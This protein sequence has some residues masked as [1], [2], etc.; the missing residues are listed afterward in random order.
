MNSSKADVSTW[1]W[2]IS[3]IIV[4]ALVF[5]AAYYNLGQITMQS[6]KQNVVDKYNALLRNINGICLTSVGNTE[7]IQM[8]LSKEVRAIYT[9]ATPTIP[10]DKADL[11]VTNGNSTKGIYLC[12]QFYTEMDRDE[13]TCMRTDCEID[14]L[15][16]GKPTID[17]MMEK[18]A[19]LTGGVYEFNLKVI[20][21]DTNLV[22]ICNADGARCIPPQACNYIT[23]ASCGREPVLALLNSKNM[24]LLADTSP[25][26]VCCAEDDTAIL[27]KNIANYFGG[28]KVLIVWEDKNIDPT[29]E[30]FAP[31]KEALPDK[32]I[33]SLRHLQRIDY[34]SIKEFD[35]IWIFA[36]GWCQGSTKDGKKRISEE[37]CSNVVPWDE[38][39]IQALKKYL[40]KGGKILLTS[41]YSTLGDYIF[42]SQAIPNKIVATIDEFAYFK[43]ERICEEAE[44]NLMIDK[45]LI[46]DGVKK[47]LIGYS[48]AVSCV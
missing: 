9:T 2:I 17:S 19:S 32:E 36:P 43:T 20:K 45:H 14:M 6:S 22:K 34:D 39:E 47:L 21:M 5:A 16:I 26:Y 13:F 11:L 7:E 42:M 3:G 27:L 41:E 18:K 48:T 33:L 38:S 1:I 15:Y 29:N 12:L 8:L 10:P 24:V 25:L 35:Q 23:L 37:Y 30:R 4:A 46:T 40:S 44:N 28:T 31:L